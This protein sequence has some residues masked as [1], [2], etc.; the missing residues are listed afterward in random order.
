[1]GAYL[2]ARRHL[3][4]ERGAEAMAVLFEAPMGE[5]TWFRGGGGRGAAT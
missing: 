4:L 5:G 3:P 1:M 2:L